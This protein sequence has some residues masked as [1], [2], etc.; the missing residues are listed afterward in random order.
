MVFERSSPMSETIVLLEAGF[1]SDEEAEEPALE[2]IKGMGV[3]L[4]TGGMAETGADDGKPEHDADVDDGEE[5]RLLL[6]ISLRLRVSCSRC[7]NSVCRPSWRRGRRKGRRER[8][9]KKVRM[10]GR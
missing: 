2:A 1:P 9:R 7:S 4:A 5:E 10:R 6:S 3:S 8:V